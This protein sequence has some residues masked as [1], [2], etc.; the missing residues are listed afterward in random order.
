[1]SE[2]FDILSNKLLI[3]YLKAYG[4]CDWFENNILK[5]DKEIEKEKKEL[6]DRLT[7]DEDE[8]EED[9]DYSISIS[10]KDLELCT[11]F[12]FSEDN[13][14]V[15]KKAY[16]AC[17]NADYSSC[18]AF[19]YEI[20]ANMNY[21]SCKNNNKIP[22]TAGYHIDFHYLMYYY[23][24]NKNAKFEKVE[25]EIKFNIWDFDSPDKLKTD[26]EMDLDKDFV[27]AM[28]DLEGKTFKLTN[29]AQYE[30]K[31]YETTIFLKHSNTSDIS[32]IVYSV[33]CDCD[34]CYALDRL[35]RTYHYI[36][37]LLDNR[38]FIDW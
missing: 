33:N 28:M 35:F 16:S 26:H 10:N 5:S 12:N 19:V 2:E 1:M 34:R 27:L 11:T 18:L 25:T 21:K 29:S 31:D 38:E 22:S 4:N 17:W 3:S 30:E 6:L 37:Y 24:I 8:G 7:F 15:D 9:E 13:D 36:N 20:F 23:V 32:K 14:V